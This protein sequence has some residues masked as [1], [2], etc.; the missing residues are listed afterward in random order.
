MS[1]LLWLVRVM[2]ALI[3]LCGFTIVLIALRGYRGSNSRS[4]AYLA[5]GFA[6]LTIGSVIE[7]IFYEIAGVGLLEAHA[8]ETFFQLAGFLSVIYGIYAR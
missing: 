6:F 1:Q 8:V 7:G 4:L 5:A 3:I 2:E